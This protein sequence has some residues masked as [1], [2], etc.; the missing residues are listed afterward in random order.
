MANTN[1]PTPITMTDRELAAD[2]PAANRSPLEIGV[3]VTARRRGSARMPTADAATAVW[4]SAA[5][6]ATRASDRRRS[7]RATR[8]AMTVI[9]SASSIE[10]SVTT[11]RID[12]S[13]SVAAR[14][15]L[16]AVIRDDD[17]SAQRSLNSTATSTPRLST[18]S[19]MPSAPTRLS[20]R[21]NSRTLEV[22]ST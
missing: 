5:S 12:I 6:A 7:S 21:A 14:S 17:S 15:S 20:P 1:R 8:H 2:G 18:D 9:T 4:M 11:S 3:G 10:T 19:T 22:P 13:L 16:A